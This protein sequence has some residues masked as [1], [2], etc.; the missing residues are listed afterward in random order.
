MRADYFTQRFRRGQRSRCAI[1]PQA[2][3]TGRSWLDVHRSRYRSLRHFAGLDF[4]RG[5]LAN[6]DATLEI[7]AILNADALRNHIA[8]QGTLVA[9]VDAVAGIDIAIDLGQERPLRGQRYWRRPD[10]CGPPR[11]DSLGD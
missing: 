8:S 5:W 6:I 1:L 9:D 2:A 3:E 4:G 7:G 10:R 11:R